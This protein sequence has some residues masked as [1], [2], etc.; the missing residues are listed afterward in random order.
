MDIIRDAASG[1]DIISGFINIPDGM[2]PDG[3]MDMEVNYGE[4]A[5]YDMIHSRRNGFQMTILKG[6]YY[7]CVAEIHLT[8]PALQRKADRFGVCGEDNHGNLVTQPL[9]RTQALCLIG[10]DKHGKCKCKGEA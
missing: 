3:T 4:K 6:T 9:T 10:R 8:N 5:A 2:F 7:C 1:S